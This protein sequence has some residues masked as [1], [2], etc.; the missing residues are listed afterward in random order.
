MGE[1]VIL[2]LV[3]CSSSHAVWWRTSFSDAD[4]ADSAQKMYNIIK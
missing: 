4:S 3:E 1:N 2:N